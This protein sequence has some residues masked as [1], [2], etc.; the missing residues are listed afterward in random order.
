M[1]ANP[2]WGLERTGRLLELEPGGDL[3]FLLSAH[4]QRLM[5]LGLAR[6]STKVSG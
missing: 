2:V 3:P 1:T 4:R 6:Y 5:Q